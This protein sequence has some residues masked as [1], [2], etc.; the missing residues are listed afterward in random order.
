MVASGLGLL[1][2]GTLLIAMVARTNKLM[3][4]ISSHRSGDDSHIVK[5][6]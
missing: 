4:K 3:Q 6:H 1:I 5:N 2:I